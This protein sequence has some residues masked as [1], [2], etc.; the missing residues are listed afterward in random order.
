MTVLSTK[1]LS[2]AQKELLLNAGLGLVEYDAIRIEPLEFQWPQGFSD[3]IF[4]SSNAVRICMQNPAAK[5]ALTNPANRIYCVGHKTA[6]LFAKNG[7]KVVEIGENASDLGKKIIKSGQNGPFLF[8]CGSSRRD[9][10]PDLL[11]SAKKDLFELKVYKT[12]PVLKNFAQNWTEILFFSPSGVKSYT[13]ANPEA[14][15]R[16][17]CIGETTAEEASKYTDRVV[18]ANQASIES[19]IAKTAKTL[20]HDQERSIS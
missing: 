15:F 6:A 1:I 14:H 16:A 17:F 5:S 12:V 8:C 18:V 13:E 9:E 10:L 19:V 20:K 7:Q 11:N 4:S 2:L 3:Y